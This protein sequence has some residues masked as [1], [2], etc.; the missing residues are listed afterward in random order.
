MSKKC[1][2]TNE[3]VRKMLKTGEKNVKKFVKKK[4]II[5]PIAAYVVINRDIHNSKSCTTI[6]SRNYQQK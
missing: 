5:H 2:K 3:N 4:Y 6:I 1:Q